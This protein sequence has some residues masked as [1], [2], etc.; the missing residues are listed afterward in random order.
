MEDLTTLGMAVRDGF[1]DVVMLREVFRV[2]R[3]GDDM[4]EA[5][6]AALRSFLRGTDFDCTDET[7]SEV[8]RR[9]LA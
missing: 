4:P 7:D 6:R 1:E 9:F 8:Y 2:D 3:G 5:E